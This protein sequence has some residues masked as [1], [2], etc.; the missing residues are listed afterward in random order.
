MYSSVTEAIVSV[1]IC[2]LHNE[3]L[4]P[5]YS[6]SHVLARAEIRYIPL[7]KHIFNLV[8]SARN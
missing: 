3:K 8:V 1:V 6:M 2:S 5:V 4:L 7:E